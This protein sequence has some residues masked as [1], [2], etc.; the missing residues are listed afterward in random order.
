LA[1]CANFRK[2]SFK[3]ELALIFKL[4]KKKKRKKDADPEN[5]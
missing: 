5:A 3:R 4:K 2:F 1:G